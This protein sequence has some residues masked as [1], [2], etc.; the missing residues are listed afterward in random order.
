[1]IT[2]QI[3]RVQ[4]LIDCAIKNRAEEIFIK[5]LGIDHPVIRQYVNIQV[6]TPQS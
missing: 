3:N 4:F 2:K 1:M 5:L 6:Y